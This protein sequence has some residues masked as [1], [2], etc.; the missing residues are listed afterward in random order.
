MSLLNGCFP[1]ILKLFLLFYDDIDGS[2]GRHVVNGASK[3]K[4]KSKLLR[5]LILCKL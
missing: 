2:P 5:T 1:I 4:E 3:G